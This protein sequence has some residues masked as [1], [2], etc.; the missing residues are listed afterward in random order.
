M[1]AQEGNEEENRTAPRELSYLLL[2]MRP[3]LIPSRHIYPL[4][5]HVGLGISFISHD[6]HRESVLLI[7]QCFL[8]LTIFCHHF[9]SLRLLHVAVELRCLKF[10]W[11]TISWRA[12][13]KSFCAG[14]SQIYLFVSSGSRIFTLA[15]GV[16][17]GQL[18]LSHLT[19]VPYLFFSSFTFTSNKKCLFI[20]SC[21]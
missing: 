13:N 7:S 8:Y 9:H 4:L 3:F 1:R 20:L 10:S 14:F 5:A 15:P 6:R 18:P 19:M 21:L 12:R 2:K 16:V 11:A 17:G